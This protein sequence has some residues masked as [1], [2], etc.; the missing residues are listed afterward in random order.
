MKLESI[1]TTAASNEMARLIEA[2]DWEGSPLLSKSG[3]SVWEP[4]RNR[5]DKTISGLLHRD[6]FPLQ[7]IALSWQP[8]NAMVE[9]WPCFA[10]DRDLKETERHDGSDTRH[11]RL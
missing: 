6:A 8:S 7:A 1:D 5:I 9:Q 2:H 3:R 4:T 10:V 11:T